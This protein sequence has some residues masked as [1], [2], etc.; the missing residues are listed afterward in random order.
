MFFIQMK[1]NLQRLLECSYKFRLCAQRRSS[2]HRKLGL[3]VIQ[4]GN[5]MMLVG[6]FHQMPDRTS[7]WKYKN[8]KL[9]FCFL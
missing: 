2:D 3:Y 9:S 5:A 1:L 8:N 6:W 4:L 7:T